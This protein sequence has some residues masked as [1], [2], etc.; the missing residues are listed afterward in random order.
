MAEIDVFDGHCDTV[1]MCSLFSGGFVH[2]GFHVDLERAGKYRRYA[3]FF[4]L[5]GQPEDF[6]GKDLRGMSFSEIFETE[7][8][9]FRREMAANAHTIVH[10]RTMAEAEQAFAQKKSAAFLSVEGAELLDCSPE[11]LEEA[12]GLGVRAVTL[13]WNYANALS[14]SNQ[15]ET[16]RGLT[17]QG[18]DFVRKAEQLGMLVDV[19]HLSDAGFWDVADMLTGPFFA[20]HSNAR[21]V[22]SHPRNLT[23]EQFTAIIDHGGVAGLNLYGEFL[24]DRPDVDTVIAHLDRWLA[25]GGAQNIS[26]GGDLDGCSMLPAGFTGVESWELLYERL[27][28]RNYHESLIRD[29]FFNNLMRV[30]SKVCIM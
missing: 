17:A 24:G 4:A 16:D 11:R 18:K 13:T 21:A 10:C 3:Q 12:Y 5:F 7:Y 14:G 19:S 26:L 28:Q 30:V 2:N 20:S 6:P 15:E 8:A 25:L 23:D 27:L 22:F 1:L 29:V 9:L